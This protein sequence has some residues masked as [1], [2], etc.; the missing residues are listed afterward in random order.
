M[1]DL[2]YEQVIK[3]KLST[4]KELFLAQKQE[5]LKDE[6]F[7]DFFK[8]NKHW[9]IPYAAF[10]YLR[11]RNGTSNFNEWKLY[12]KYEK[13]AIEKYVSPKAKHY[14]NIALQYFIQYH[15]HKQLQDAAEYA[16]KNGIILKGDIPIGIYRYGC[17]AWVQ[18]ELLP[19]RSAGRCATG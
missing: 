5:F 18:P 13:E 9:L 8:T 2:D 16:H 11:D 6:E 15:L 10:C 4:L 1:S 7:L 12:S 3:F 17:D 14:D 19:F